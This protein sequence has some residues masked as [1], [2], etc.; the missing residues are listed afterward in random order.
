MPQPIAGSIHKKTVKDISLSG[1]RLL[2]RVDFNV[3]LDASG[4]ITDDTRIKETLPTIKYC[5]GQKAI[6]IIM[7]HLGRPDGKRSDKYSLLPCAKH[8]ATLLG[9]PVA[10]IGDCIGKE[11][12]EKVKGL[13]P[14]EILVL[15][16]VRFYA[17][18]EKND[19]EFA[20][21]LAALGEIYCND[22][23]GAA[24]RAHA[25]TEGVAHYLP[26]VAGFLMEKE[27][28]YLSTALADPAKP[29]VAILGG[30]KVSDKIKVIEKLMEKVDRLII[31]GGMCYTFLKAL[32]Y[33]IG[34]S[35]LEAERIDLAKALLE[36]AKAK[37]VEVLLPQDHVITTSLDVG[38]EVKTTSDANVPDGWLGA[39]IGPKTVAA[40]SKA[41]SDAKTVVWNGP[42]GVFEQER[43]ASGSRKIAEVLA[44]SGATTVIGGGDTASCVK[45]FGLGDKMSHISTGGGASLE[46]LEGKDLPGISILQNK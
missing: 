24:H 25:S 31:G 8:L 4:A 1:K 44:G 20:K 12:E 23:F 40:F 16:N 14:G 3:P 35:K 30:A 15:E 28:K 32:G 19:P 26:A 38:S 45:Q 34:N 17:Q 2:M 27:I 11:V 9:M 42:M 21:S 13:K 41:L 39:D 5:L 29:Y 10:F 46:Y 33:S 18:E 36:K 6:I 7:S 37:S 43:F 22:A